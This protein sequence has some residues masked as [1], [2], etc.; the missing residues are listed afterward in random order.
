MG[1]ASGHES[2]VG[3]S[4]GK[5]RWRTIM[6][7]HRTGTLA[8]V[9]AVVLAA[10]TP[11][12]PPTPAMTCESLDTLT[13]GQQITATAAPPGNSFQPP[14]MDI[15][16]HPFTFASGTQ[17]TGGFAKIETG[18]HAGGA[19]NEINVNNIMLSVSRGFGATLQKIRLSFG[20]YGGNLIQC[21]ANK[22]SHD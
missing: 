13:P 12:P 19:G 5:S 10:C 3:S 7:A 18:L 17:T 1:G 9:S 14:T 22:F 2:R 15:A 11:T 21:I 4:S 8:V 20:E 6:V 16:A